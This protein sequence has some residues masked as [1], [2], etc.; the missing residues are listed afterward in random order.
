M[1]VPI[2]KAALK[3]MRQNTRRWLRNVRMQSE[4]RTLT[5][6]FERLLQQQQ[7]PQARVQLAALLKRIDQAQG[8]GILHRNTAARKKSRLASRLVQ[9][10]A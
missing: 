6:K 7:V 9:S 8:K 5:K 4:L 10:P 3:A 1:H 2:K